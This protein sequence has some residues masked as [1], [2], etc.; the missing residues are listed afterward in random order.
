MALRSESTF[1][2][3]S[4]VNSTSR[5]SLALPAGVATVTDK[6]TVIT[7]FM[8]PLLLFRTMSRSIY[9]ASILFRS[10]VSMSRHRRRVVINRYRLALVGIRE[11][12]RLVVQLVIHL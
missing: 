12:L 10:G 4:G 9:S 2:T 6:S 7:V 3:S 8:A 1:S 11:A 5:L